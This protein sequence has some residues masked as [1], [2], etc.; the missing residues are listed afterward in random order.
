VFLGIK[1][2]ILVSIHVFFFFKEKNLFFVFVLSKP[3]FK[4]SIWSPCVCAS[5]RRNL[6]LHRC[7]LHRVSLVIARLCAHTTSSFSMQIE[8]ICPSKDNDV[9]MKD[10]L[11]Q[12]F[13]HL[14][15]SFCICHHLLTM[16]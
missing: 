13:I 6:P 12:D 8:T 16:S 10:Q 3:F 4:I 5:C 11:S 9:V 1:F 14:L 7:Q 2:I 15:S